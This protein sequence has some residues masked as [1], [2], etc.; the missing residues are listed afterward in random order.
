MT[1][2]GT[3]TRILK[4]LYGIDA[5]LSG[6]YGELDDNFLASMANGEKR[7]LKIMHVGCDPQRVDFQCEAMRHLAGTVGELNL[8]QVIPTSSGQGYTELDIEGV[9]RLVWSLKYCPGT[10]LHDISAHSD[11]LLRSFGR[12]MALVDLGLKSFSHPAMKQGHKWD[13]TLA[14]ATRPFVKYVAAEAASQVEAVLGHFESVTASRLERLPRSVIHN[15]ANDGNVLVNTGDDGHAVV[16]GLIDFGDMS[17]Q[18]IICEAAIALADV[19]EDKD[20]PLTACATFL[21]AYKEHY[22][23]SGE[24]IAVLFD[25]IK[26]R[27]AV[28]IAIASERHHEDPDDMLGLQDK[29]P[30]MRALS[31][32]AAYSSDEAESL[33]LLA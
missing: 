17:H 27:L 1:S 22:P 2:T 14:G 31:R 23:L 7:I 5:E 24:E 11:E 26:T 16:D 32:L 4:D 3:A 21:A 18:P 13:L 28:S 15:D 6:L 8:P 33:F 29:R 10:M 9:R 30:A 19:V 20:E 25:L 12:V